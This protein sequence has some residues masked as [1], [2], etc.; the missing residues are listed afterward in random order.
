MKSDWKPAT[1]RIGVLVGA[2][3]GLVGTWIFYGRP[4]DDDPYYTL[5]FIGFFAVVGLLWSISLSLDNMAEALRTVAYPVRLL[6][7]DP[8]G[9]MDAGEQY[10]IRRKLG[11]N[12]RWDSEK[13]IHAEEMENLKLLHELEEKRKRKEE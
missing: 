11:M 7:L 6:L 13:H 2:T 1:L 5:L 12:V 8:D 10:K 9:D 4:G 3:V